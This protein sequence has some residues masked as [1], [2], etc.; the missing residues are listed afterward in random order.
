MQRNKLNILFIL[1]LIFGCTQNSKDSKSEQKT[2]ATYIQTDNF[3]YLD[4]ANFPFED[5]S[6]EAI[7]GKAVKADDKVLLSY[8]LNITN[9]FT[10]SI[11]I[12]KI[13]V[14]DF[15]KK[16][17]ISTF[18]STYLN[19]H[20]LRPG[21]ENYA[22]VLEMKNNG[23]GIA[24]LW[25]SLTDEKVPKNF[26]H[27]IHFKIQNENG[28]VQEASVDLALQEFPEQTKLQIG[29]PFRKGKWFYVANAHRDARLITEGKPTFPQRYAIDWV[30]LTSNNEFLVDSNENVQ[31]FNTFQ[32]DLLAVSNGKV[33]FTKDGI[34]DNN[35]FK[36]NFD[37]EI[38]RETV[39]G[40]YVVLDIGNGTYAFY[41]HLMPGSVTVDVGDIVKKGDVIGKLG[42][43]G[44]SFLPHLHFHLE[45]KSKYPLGG[46]GI[47]YTIESFHQL[48][49]FEDEEIPSILASIQIPLEMS[50][51]AI[52]RTN[53]LPIGNGVIEFK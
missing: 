32:A 5:L 19:L 17:V 43:S 13:D 37:I 46:E 1:I 11:V 36:D 52:H 47:P 30:S 29:L 25:L 35:P 45:T 2:V 3:Q 15:E 14:I 21:I 20:F 31:S 7:I 41:G 8:E 42:N 34:P 49:F 50:K 6:G 33:V 22:E 12:S 40:N 9:A 38:T 10:N 4:K 18:D 48:A 28:N 53:S 26:F 23:F 51:N 24:N 27:R 16:K 39:A 44:R